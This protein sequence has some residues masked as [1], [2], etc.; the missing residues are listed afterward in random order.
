[1]KVRVEAQPAVG[2]DKQN[3]TCEMIGLMVGVVSMFVV[4]IGL[5]GLAAYIFRDVDPYF[6]VEISGMEGIDPLPSR[7]IFL[8]LNLTLGVDNGRQIRREC[9]KK[10]TVTISYS[11]VDITWGEVPAFCVNGLSTTELSI[12]LSRTYGLLPRQL[13]DRM[14]TD[15]H[16]GQLELGV[17]MK[18]SCPQDAH[19]LCYLSCIIKWENLRW[20]LEVDGLLSIFG[21]LQESTGLCLV[22][23]N[24]LKI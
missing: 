14:A 10:S 15:V 17:E 4:A 20:Y 8:K 9:R 24:S 7:V 19:W 2:G 16:V 13:R 6:S 21:C 18:P 23:R 1:M 5:L 3:S 12:P 22:R 11:R